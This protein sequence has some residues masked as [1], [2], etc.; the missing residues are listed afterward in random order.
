MPRPR[1]IVCRWC[2]KGFHPKG[3]FLH[4]RA[5]KKKSQPPAR[6]EVVNLVA[7]H[8]REVLRD[9]LN[10]LWNFL[11]DS[12]KMYALAAFYSRAYPND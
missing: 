7:K 8:P 12:E 11:N 4:D 1:K 9:S 10:G 3:I 5:C 6:Q 2:S